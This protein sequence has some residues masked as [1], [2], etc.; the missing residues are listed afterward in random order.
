MS[1]KDEPK[2]TIPQTDDWIYVGALPYELT[3]GDVICVFSQYGEINQI[4]FARDKDTGKP[5]GFCFLN[6]EDSR[7]CQL[8]VDNLDRATVVG[9]RLKVSMAY[10]FKPSSKNPPVDVRPKCI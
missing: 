6:Y 7:S 2:S 1:R 9:R 10:N 3:E 5:K 8:A 4:S